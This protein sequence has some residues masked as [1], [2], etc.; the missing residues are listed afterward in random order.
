MPVRNAVQILF[1]VAVCLVFLLGNN[2]NFKNVFTQ[3]SMFVS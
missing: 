3:I 2:V 1:V